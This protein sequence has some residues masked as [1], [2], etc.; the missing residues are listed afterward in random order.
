MRGFDGEEGVVG[1]DGLGVWTLATIGKPWQWINLDRG[2]MGDVP[3]EHW[4]S[5]TFTV[6]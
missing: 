6:I 1:D 5:A 2:L 3:L 4:A